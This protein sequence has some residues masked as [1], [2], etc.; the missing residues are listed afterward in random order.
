MRGSVGFENTGA[1]AVCLT[2]PMAFERREIK[3]K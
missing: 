1:A 2:E 3:R